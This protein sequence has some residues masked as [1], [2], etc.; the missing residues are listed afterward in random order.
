VLYASALSAAAAAVDWNWFGCLAMG[1]VTLLVAL[2]KAGKTTLIGHLLRALQEGKPFLG[3]AT[4]ETRTLVVSEESQTIWAGRRDA[5]GLDD[6]LSLLCK[7]TVAKLNYGEWCEFIGYVGEQAA[8][9]E[10]DLV[11]FDTLGTFAPWKNENESAEVN[12]AVLPF[13]RLTE[14]GR[15]VL[16]FHHAGKT[17]QG[18]GKAARGS[19]ALAAAVDIILEMRR[20]KPDDRTDRRR[21]LSGLGRFDEVP[22]ELVIALADDGTGYTAEG[23]RKE[24]AARELA[25]AIL[26]VL[27]ADRPGLRGDEVHEAMPK[28]DRPGLAKIGAALLSGAEAGRWQ[29][30]GSGRKGDPRR[31]WRS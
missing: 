19:T 2:M 22:D 1:H 14:A 26:D 29:A 16:G 23:D 27:P 7:P 9:R 25:D 31:Y 15:G 12:A 28:G 10:C 6:H 5:L 17:D 21:V 3:R 11:A 18:E 8:E 24:L 20:F 13:N 4:R 30:S